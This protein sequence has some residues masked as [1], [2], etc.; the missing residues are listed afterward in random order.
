MAASGS[1]NLSQLCDADLVE[2]VRQGEMA[3]Y[4]VLWQRHAESGH[5]FARGT[6]SSVSAEDAVSEAFET[7]LSAIKRGL[8][9]TKS[10]RAYMRTTIRHSV[11]RTA[12]G[13][14]ETPVEHLGVDE[15][16]A[17]ADP[18]ESY[19][20]TSFDSQTIWTAFSALNERYQLVL[21]L[22]E[23]EGLKPREIAVQLNTSTANVSVV[24][25]RAREAFRRNYDKA[26]GPLGP[27][28]V[29]TVPE[30]PRPQDPAD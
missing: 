3:A 30:M 25:F 13:N 15:I 14:V 9:P 6:N 22:S 21:W 2:L 12:T 18:S 11:A 7:M 20:H 28:P 27:I 1:E 8:G 29:E 4:H 26:T 16:A 19:A 23:V 17:G 10:F 5:V 24:A